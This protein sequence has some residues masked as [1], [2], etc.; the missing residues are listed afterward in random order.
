MTSVSVELLLAGYGVGHPSFVIVEVDHHE[1]HGGVELK[2]WGNEQRH[3][4]R[5][6]GRGRR[7]AS[8]RCGAVTG[9]AQ[10]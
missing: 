6:W 2:T 7:R 3:R 4:L 8:G 10:R 5:W 9:P 1:A